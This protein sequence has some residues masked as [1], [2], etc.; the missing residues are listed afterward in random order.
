MKDSFQSQNRKKYKK[1]NGCSRLPSLPMIGAVIFMVTLIVL[2]ATIVSDIVGL[3]KAIL[4]L[5]MVFS[6][7]VLVIIIFDYVCLI[8]SDPVDPRLLDESFT[9]RAKDLLVWC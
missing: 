1:T 2:H 4:T 7:L 9:E 8:I 3:G 5:M 6:Y